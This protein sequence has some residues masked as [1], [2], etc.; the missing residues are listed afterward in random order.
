MYGESKNAPRLP[1]AV[2][3]VRANPFLASDES[4]E[5]REQQNSRL[6]KVGRIVPFG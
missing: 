1:T 4:V 5:A 6:V 3:P 2:S